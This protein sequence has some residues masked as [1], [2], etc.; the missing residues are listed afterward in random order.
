[1]TVKG[2]DISHWQGEIDWEKIPDEYKFA[3]M[4]ATEGDGFIDDRFTRNWHSSKPGL[5]GAYHFWRY[6][7]DG[8]AQAEHF[9]D[10]VSKTG[11]LGELPP[12][13]DLEDTRAPKGGDIAIRMRQML[14]RT[15]ELFGVQPIIYTANWWWSPWTLNNTGFGDY[16]LWVAHYKTVY[17]WSKPYLPAGWDDWQVWQHSSK[18]SVPGVD[19]NCDLNVAKDEWYNKYVEP[20]EPAYTVEVIAPRGVKVNVTQ[21]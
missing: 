7:F 16:E 10:I 20:E 6:A 1:M 14:Q 18:G 17:P 3:F 8:T 12:V 21:H 5:R 13:I 4:K 15:E 2:I 9:F 11:D 19:G